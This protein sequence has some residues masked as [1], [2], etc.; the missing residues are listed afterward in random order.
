M[1]FI[2]ELFSDEGKASFSR[3]GTFLLLLGTLF[4]VSYLVVKKETMP[5]LASLTLLLVS[6][7]GV[8]KAASA[9]EGFKK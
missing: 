8:N 9:V 7:Y 5:D 6:L 4:W 1:R 2:R 3:F